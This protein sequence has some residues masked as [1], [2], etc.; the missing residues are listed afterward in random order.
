M[1]MK[2]DIAKEKEK[3][4]KASLSKRIKF[5]DLDRA[6]ATIRIPEYQSDYRKLLNPD[7]SSREFNK[8]LTVKKLCK[9]I[10]TDKLGIKLKSEKNT[11]KWLNEL[12]RSPDLLDKLLKKKGYDHFEEEELPRI[13]KRIN[14]HKKE[15]ETSQDN[16]YL[17]KLNRYLIQEFYPHETPINISAHTKE[18]REFLKKWGLNRVLTSTVLEEIKN[19]KVSGFDYH[20]KEKEK[21][22]VPFDEI[23]EK[24]PQKFEKHRRLLLKNLFIRKPLHLRV[25]VDLNAPI[26]EN[27]FH[28]KKDIETYKK[29]IEELDD[30]PKKRK[31]GNIYSL[32]EVYDLKKKRLNL[33]QIARKLSGIDGNP[34]H[35]SIV[36]QHFDSVKRA[37][38]KA[39]KIMEEVRK[40][41]GS[42]N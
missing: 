21:V 32:W 36:R 15:Y 14:K 40:D 6:E 5:S 18:E 7:F 42:Y 37:F 26:K 29:V 19:P 2:K 1:E 20:P 30:E 23:E 41:A 3:N 16:L 4:I 8:E 13:R 11:I 31:R 34:S 25:K 33:S 28:V 38:K 27:L 10:T 22:L 17:R 39:E 24:L 9:A 35:D 12:L